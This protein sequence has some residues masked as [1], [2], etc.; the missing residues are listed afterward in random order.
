M[1]KRLIQTIAEENLPESQCD[2]R[3]N[4]NKTD[5]VIVLY[6]L[7]EKCQEQNK[8]L[9]ATFVDLTKAFEAVSRREVWLVL[10]RLGCPPI[11]LQMVIKLHKN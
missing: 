2:F 3:V 11:I 10:K 1:L 8:S 4:R 6:Q 9:Y 7:L 5:M